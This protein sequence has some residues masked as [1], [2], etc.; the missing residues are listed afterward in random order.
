MANVANASEQWQ[1][2]IGCT[3]LFGLILCLSAIGNTQAAPGP[4]NPLGAETMNKYPGLLPELGRMFDKLQHNVTFPPDRSDSRLLP[5]LPASTIGYL[6]LP[7]YGG[8]ARQALTI[9]QQ[10][11]NASPDLRAWWADSG[12]ATSGPQIEDALDRFSKISEYIGDEIVIS[13]TLEGREP[14]LLLIAEVRR[15]GF[16][17]VL[18]NV[19]LNPAAKEKPNL[20]I[21]DPQELATTP[22]TKPQELLILV[23]PDF[24]IASNSLARLRSFTLHLDRGVRDFSANP[25]AQR[26]LRSYV[27]GISWVGALDLEKL[28]AQIPKDPS[29]P[30]FQQTG[31]ADVKYAVWEHRS[32]N[33]RSISQSE[34]S[35]TGI[36]H[37]IAAWLAAPQ[38]LGGLDFVSPKTMFAVALVL[39][40]PALIFNDIRQLSDSNPNALA[41]LAQMEQALGFSL[42]QDVLAQ[43]SGEITIE[44][45]N[46]APKPAWRAILGVKDA[47]LL[48]QTLATILGRA[49]LPVSEYSSAGVVYHLLNLPSA[50]GTNVIA[51][52]LVD[53]YLLIGSTPDALSEAVRVHN[54]GESLGRSRRFTDS[55]PRGQAG[56][57]ALLYE[58]PAA[59]MALQMLHLSP[60]QSQYMTQLM[61]KSNPVVMC[62]YG[63]PD[64]IR[65]AST[66]PGVD[67]GVILVGAAIAIPNLL[68]ARIAANEASAV[69]KLRVVNTAQVTYAYAYR[70]RG[71][72]PD[73]AT[74]GTD[75][76]QRSPSFAHA[77]LLD[78]P[79]G[80][81]AC[82]GAS[83]CEFS[84]YR[85]MLRGSC[86]SGRCRDF[87]IAAT[88]VTANT[89][90]RS[91][92]STSDGVIRYQLASPLSIPPAPRDCK[93]WS[94]IR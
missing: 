7:N 47:D 15:P 53:H 75:P 69:G 8:A 49:R 13:G 66:N 76:S 84:G 57:S 56:A 79:L 4:P 50:Q 88:P 65:E 5:L 45:D 31:F 33:E 81:V 73:L 67:A 20:R 28:V 58:D 30:K 68:R 43:L 42:Q 27:G 94:P 85:F 72:A 32:L 93:Q 83:W 11:L 14:D 74:L 37:G 46:I 36:R 26:I 38:P 60:S 18:Q 63:E 82:T 87:V 9:F 35:F 44:L 25:F 10:E 89:G 39:K 1:F 19:V 54:R 59:M 71:F 34:L 6:A 48:E 92:C 55:L 86:A 21:L 51:Y 3:L 77:G 80:N 91:F 29:F 23:R 52:A 12:M 70:S 90:N 22:D 16:K 41:S 24:V 62:A 17:A 61:G 78:N 2:C 40:N 64:A